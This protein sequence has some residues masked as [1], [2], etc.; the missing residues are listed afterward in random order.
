MLD[1]LEAAANKNKI[2]YIR[3]DGSVSS[4]E[5]MRRVTQFQSDETVQVAILGL[6]AAGVGITLTAAST[7]VFSEL[8]WTP[9][10]LVQAEDRVHR[11]GQKSSVN[12]HYLVAA[13]TVDDM[14]WNSV[15]HKIEVVSKVCDGRTD[16]LVAG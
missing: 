14:I 15:G 5:R 3:I 11:I 9:G 13:D 10:V 1:A 12:I 6:L 8:H 4:A 2:K 16:H 7:V